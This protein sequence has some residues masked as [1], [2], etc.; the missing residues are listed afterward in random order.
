MA[1]TFYQSYFDNY[2][3]R[4]ECHGGCSWNTSKGQV[5]RPPFILVSLGIGLQA[6]KKGSPYMAAVSALQEVSVNKAL[7]VALVGYPDPALHSCWMSTK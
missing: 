5:P 6:L 3:N 7:L 4:R 2:G 1:F